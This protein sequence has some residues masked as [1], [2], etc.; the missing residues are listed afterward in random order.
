LLVA[1]DVADDE[2]KRHTGE[3]II[4]IL[5]A[6]ESK[7]LADAILDKAA[8]KDL[9]AKKCMVR[10]VRAGSLDVATRTVA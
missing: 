5:K 9:P 4:A 8:L 1:V 2:A 3:G 10:P 7:L 6:L